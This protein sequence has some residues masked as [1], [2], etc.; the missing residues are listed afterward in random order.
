MLEG[1]TSPMKFQVNEEA[2]GWLKFTVSAEPTLKV[3]QLMNAF[4]ED[5]LMFKVEPELLIVAEPCVTVP[6]VG[7]PMTV[8]R[9]AS[10]ISNSAGQNEALQNCARLW[11]INSLKMIRRSR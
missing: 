9:P 3:C 11:T 4:A 10:Q 8:H 7:L 2:E 1:F 5:W 6:P